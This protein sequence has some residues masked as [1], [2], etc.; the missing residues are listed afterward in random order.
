[1]EFSIVFKLNHTIKISFMVS[2]VGKIHYTHVK[3]PLVIGELRAP[4]GHSLVFFRY[5]NKHQGLVVFEQLVYCNQAKNKK[6]I[7]NWGH[8]SL[9][10]HCV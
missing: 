6:K 2:D 9:I 7:S 1:M 8:A 3:N 5:N 4:I 10:N